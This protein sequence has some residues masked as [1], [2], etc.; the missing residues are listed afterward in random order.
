[1]QCHERW[2]K[3][4][5]ILPINFE[6]WFAVEKREYVSNSV[7]VSTQTQLQ[8]K[9]FQNIYVMLSNWYTFLYIS[10][11]FFVDKLVLSPFDLIFYHFVLSVNIL[12][13]SFFTLFS[14]SIFH[15]PRNIILESVAH[16]LHQVQ[17]QFTSN[18]VPF[19]R[20]V[21][22]QNKSLHSVRKRFNSDSWRKD[23]EFTGRVEHKKR[24]TSKKIII[25]HFNRI[26]FFLHWQYLNPI[27]E[28]KPK[29]YRHRFY[30]PNAKLVWN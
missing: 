21:L 19:H 12:L 20:N 28:K 10:R 8:Y 15:F 14:I 5:I 22:K 26:Y 23:E 17:L 27:L 13:Y 2:E 4:S 25:S 16:C 18:H 1:M 3:V 30:H 29:D 24:S 11:I 6:C 9:F 7:W